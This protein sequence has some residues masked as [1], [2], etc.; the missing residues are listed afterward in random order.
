M[1]LAKRE[2]NGVPSPDSTPSLDE[3][4]NILGYK[5]KDW[6]LLEVAL[7]HVSFTGASGSYERL[8]YVGDAVLSLMF[9]EDQYSRY[10]K[11]LPGDLTLLRAANVDTEKL[12]RVAIKLGLHRYLRHKQPLLEEKVRG[13]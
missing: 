2:E 13:R 6:S 10:P 8:E 3:V 4:E 11:L 12:A 9:A 5:F 7:T 1:M